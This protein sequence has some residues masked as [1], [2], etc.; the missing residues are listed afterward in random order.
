MEFRILSLWI[1]MSFFGIEATVHKAVTKVPIVDLV[2]DRLF[3]QPAQEVITSYDTLPLCGKRSS[4]CGRVHQLLFNEVVT[5]LDQKGEQVQVKIPSVYY[6][7]EHA[8]ERYDTY[9]A[10]KKTL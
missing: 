2:G 9:W 8:Q 7:S 3:V 6:E 1:I 5:I 10:L 4:D